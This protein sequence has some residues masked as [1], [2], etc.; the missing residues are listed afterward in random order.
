MVSVFE[1]EEKKAHPNASNYATKTLTNRRFI[2]LNSV[3]LIWSHYS[4]FIH[5]L[6]TMNTKYNTFSAV[7]DL[8]RANGDDCRYVF[9]GDFFPNTF[10][11]LTSYCAKY[12]YI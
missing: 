4:Q 6:S 12:I 11:Q 2:L 1:K 3:L 7:Y 10:A 8:K 9:L 5:L